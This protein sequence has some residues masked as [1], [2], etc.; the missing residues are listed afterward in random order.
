MD[1]EEVKKAVQL[2]A[3]EGVLS[4]QE[5]RA[6]AEKLEVAYTEVGKACNDTGVKVRYCELGCF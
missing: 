2:A 3:T 4:C 5:A 1:L 6:L